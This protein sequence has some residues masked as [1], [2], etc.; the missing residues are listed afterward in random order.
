VLIEQEIVIDRPVEEVFAFVSD[1]RN[2]PRWCRRVVSVEQVEGDGPGTGAR[3]RVVHR[4]VPLRPARE[5]DHSCRA[6]QAPHRLEWGGEDGTDKFSVVYELAADGEGTRFRQRSEPE[7]AVPRILQP[8]WGR[9]ARS[10][11]AGQLKALKQVLESE[12][13]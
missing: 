8:F 11:I 12:R 13:A 7:F 5:L 3:Y 9:G 2:D 4:P 10:E 6:C 1:A